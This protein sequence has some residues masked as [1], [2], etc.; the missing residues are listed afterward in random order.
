MGYIDIH[1]HI[2]PG[3][4][5]GSPDTQTSL[6]MLRIAVNEGIRELILTPHNKVNR[7]SA[8]PDQIRE[9][10]RRLQG[11]VDEEGIPVRLHAGM[12]IFYRE[13]VAEELDAGK[14]LT[15][16]GSRYVLV[17]FYPGEQYSTIQGA[18]FELAGNGYVPVLAHVERYEALTGDLDRVEQVIDGG[19]LIQM[20]AKTLAAAAGWTGKNKALVKGLL[21]RRLVHFISTD[22]HDVLHRPPRLEEAIRYLGRRA[23]SS[24]MADLLHDNGQLMIRNESI[25]VG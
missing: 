18:V 5:D 25:P 16:A 20:N 14:L 10:V 13:G 24:Y 19:A 9:G 2:L 23:D 21:K 1:S 15:M 4:D 7:K 17:E 8:G 6:Q 3:V 12:E 22:A 11:A